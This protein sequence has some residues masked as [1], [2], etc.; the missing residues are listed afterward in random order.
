M[1]LPLPPITFVL[2]SANIFAQATKKTLNDQRRGILFEYFGSNANHD[3]KEGRYIEKLIRYDLLWTEGFYKNDKKD[4]VWVNYGYIPDSSVTHDTRYVA[5]TGSFKNDQKTGFWKYYE[6]MQDSS[7]SKYNI[8]ISKSGS[9]EDGQRVGVWDFYD[10]KGGHQLSYD[11]TKKKLLFYRSETTDTSKQSLI[12]SGDTVKMVLDHP[13]V[14]LGT[15]NDKGMAL[16]KNLRYPTMAKEKNTQGIVWIAFTV[17]A[18][19][20]TSNFRIKK[21]IGNGCGDAALH[22]VQ[23]MEGEW[24]PAELRG[25]PVTLDYE[26]PVTFAIQIIN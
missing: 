24:A 10:S 2:I 22:A 21:D 8:Y 11:L 19:G 14:Y 15:E 26:M 16:Y 13:P 9:F 7:S 18:Q 20:K 23:L 6:K 3:I 4:S 5:S 17:D 12:S 25:K 1:K